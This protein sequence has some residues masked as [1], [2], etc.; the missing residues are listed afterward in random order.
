MISGQ[1]AESSFRRPSTAAEPASGVAADASGAAGFVA[2]G[3]V[4]TPHAAQDGVRDAGGAGR[5]PPPEKWSDLS[6][7]F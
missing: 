6:Y 5:G 3:A 2:T 4:A 1:W 7:V